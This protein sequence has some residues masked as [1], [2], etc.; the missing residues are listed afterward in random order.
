MLNVWVPVQA[1][2]LG[3]VRCEILHRRA[4][5]LRQDRHRVLS[6]YQELPECLP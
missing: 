1:M 4:G 5:F 2:D 6:I 3:E